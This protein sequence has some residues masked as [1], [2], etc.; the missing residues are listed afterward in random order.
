[1]HFT[2]FISLPA[3]VSVRTT[4]AGTLEFTAAEGIFELQQVSPSAKALI[5]S[6]H[7][8]GRRLVDLLAGS[9]DHGDS[10]PPANVARNLKRLAR[11][12]LLWL[13]VASG[14]A[15][16]ATAVPTSPDF[17]WTAS[18]LPNGPVVLSRFAYVRREEDSLLLESPTATARILLHTDAAARL[19]I[20]LAEP[21][22]PADFYLPGTDPVVTA[23]LLEL[24]ACAGFL[25]E[26][27]DD[28]ATAEDAHA[29]L[30]YWEFHDL[31]FHARSRE[32]RHDQPVGMTDHWAGVT[33]PPPACG[34]PC[35][36]EAVALFTPDLDELQVSDAPFAAVAERRRSVYDYGEKPLSAAQLGEFLYRVARVKRREELLVDT[37][38]GEVRLETTHRPYPA[39]GGLYE[40]EI[41]PVVS[42]CDGLAA[43][44]YHY[45]ATSHRLI[46]MPVQD[47]HQEQF[48]AHASMAADIPAEQL[49]VLLILAARYER[50][51]WKYSSIAYALILKDVGVLYDQMYLAATAMGLAPCALGCGDSDVFA[52]ATGRS[53]YAE[54]S[55]GEFLLGSAG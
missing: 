31:L 6:L 52:R 9:E 48:L 7:P 36:G 33:P 53:Y 26:V 35:E 13:Q 49:H 41:Y 30:R 5:E 50:I 19:P 21:V 14:V 17:S 15:A 18:R 25:T 27:V 40:L 37:G 55:V 4:D 23:G 10:L 43:G 28:G 45:D 20:A 12:G 11:H 8:P 29:A 46:R 3:G 24:W 2:W 39:A 32:G 38:S 34:P 16:V 51:A 42:R 1:M 22:S 54:A 44:M 47:T